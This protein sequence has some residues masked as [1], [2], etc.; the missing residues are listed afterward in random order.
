MR[1]W[2]METVV[3]RL[4]LAAGGVDEFDAVQ[5]DA[6]SRPFR[7]SLDALVAAA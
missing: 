4:R 2:A 3:S 7:L 1:T 6:V 5:A